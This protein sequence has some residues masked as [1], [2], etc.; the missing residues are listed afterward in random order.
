VG[1]HHWAIGKNSKHTSSVVAFQQSERGQIRMQGPNDHRGERHTTA[2]AADPGF[3][4]TA[5][6]GTREMD[7]IMPRLLG[8][9]FDEALQ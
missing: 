9:R 8:D 6:I 3:P 7:P 5:D 1:E 4:F 2:F